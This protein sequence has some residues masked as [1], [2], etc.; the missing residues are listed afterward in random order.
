MDA[1]PAADDDPT[2]VRKRLDLDRPVPLDVVQECVELAT[3]APTGSNPQGWHFVVV[4]DEAKRATLGDIY[5]KAFDVYETMPFAAG[6]LQFDDPTGPRP[7]AAG[8][9]VG[10]LPRRHHGPV[11]GARR[12]VHRGPGRR[13][14]EVRRARRSSA[15]SSRRRGASASPPATGGWARRGRRCT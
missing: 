7:A 9:V 14:A 3:Q 6:N 11:P 1:R 4:T 2:P 5:K 8:A 12:A 13:H 10:P 15:R